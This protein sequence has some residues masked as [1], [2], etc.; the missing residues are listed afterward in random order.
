M[1]AMAPVVKEQ[2]GMWIG[3]PGIEI[4]EDDVLPPGDPDSSNACDS[5]P[6]EQVSARHLTVSQ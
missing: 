4:Q 6:I 1:T 5:L 3:W 2:G